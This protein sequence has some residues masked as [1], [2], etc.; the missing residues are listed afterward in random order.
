MEIVI[1][2]AQKND[3]LFSFQVLMIALI[4]R[5]MNTDF[6]NIMLIYQFLVDNLTYGLML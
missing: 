1:L 5:N 2:E 3:K 6:K 4:Q